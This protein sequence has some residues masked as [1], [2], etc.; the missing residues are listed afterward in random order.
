LLREKSR[1]GPRLQD[2][3]SMVSPP[4]AF[5]LFQRFPEY[6]ADMPKAFWANASSTADVV[7]Q[8]FATNAATVLASTEDL[9]REQD[10]FPRRLSKVFQGLEISGRIPG[11]QRHFRVIETEFGTL[12]ELLVNGIDVEL[13]EL[14]RAI[15]LLVHPVIRLFPSWPDRIDMLLAIKK[16]DGNRGPSQQLVA[17]IAG[18]RLKEGRQHLFQDRQI[19]LLLKIL[20]GLLGSPTYIGQGYA[21][22]SSPIALDVEINPKQPVPTS[23]YAPMMAL[24]KITNRS[25]GFPRLD[26]RGSLAQAS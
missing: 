5:P 12:S 16:P 23:A 8:K 25:W 6:V 3:F 7:R 26:D 9:P 13:I 17:F 15:V 14:E 1:A 20:G 10:E 19:D 24:V 11:G 2:A 18:L 22:Q 4:D 21:F